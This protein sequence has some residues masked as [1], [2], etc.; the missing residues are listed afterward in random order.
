MTCT[1]EH[2]RP[3]DAPAISQLIIRT[4]RVSNA[5]DYTPQ[6]IAQ[7]ASTSPMVTISPLRC[8]V[9]R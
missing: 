9:M 3:A 4:L 1:I 7:V 6:V 2:A 8:E 5:R